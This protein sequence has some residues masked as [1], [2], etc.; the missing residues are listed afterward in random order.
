M[1][2]A[3]TLRALLTRWTRAILSVLT[4]AL[5]VAAVTAT[6][7]LI[8]TTHAAYTSLF[9]G[10]AAGAQIAVVPR[11]VSG[12]SVAL[13]TT[14]VQSSAPGSVPGLL[15]RR[16]AAQPGVSAAA[17]RV[18]EAATIIGRDGQP[19][20]G[21][22]LQTVAISALPA[23]FT[24]VTLLGGSAPTRPDQVA[25]DADT[26]TR[27]G[28]HVGSIIRVLTAQPARAFRVSAIAA[29][30]GGAGA[31]QRFVVFS[32]RTAQ[33]LYGIGDAYDEIEVAAA[34]GTDAGR[35]RGEVAALLPRGLEAV[36]TSTR[37]ASS[38]SRV[39]NSFRTLD[40]GLIAFAA[41]AVLI[42]S[43]IIFN[44][45]AA[46][47]TARRREYAV[48]RLL[49]AF[50]V[51]VLGSAL[52]EAGLIG[53]TGALL[54]V[55]L[56]LPL[57]LAIRAGVNAAG[58]DLPVSGL[59]IAPLALAVAFGVG[60]FVALAAALAP[61]LRVARASPA[62]ALRTGRGADRRSPVGRL[63][64]GAI[65]LA[66]ATG[67]GAGGVIVI[68][69]A[70]GDQS[71]RLV[72]CGIGVALVLLAAL[73]AAA[74]LVALTLLA[75][76]VVSGPRGRWRLWRRGRG[77]GEPRFGPVFELAREGALTSPGRR[78]RASPS[79]SPSCC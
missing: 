12:T 72:L 48:L 46:A 75:L 39:S 60:V 44:S 34:P 32:P 40:G 42:G 67:L 1:L 73:L 59:T 8:D 79:G 17:G 49:G 57:A 65:G 20:S 66:A 33:R 22:H 58:V 61:A 4:V 70:S 23:P 30:S 15:V 7:V 14:G 77:A 16:I 53:V 9:S 3:F 76:G 64:V 54:G 2:S 62:E 63:L 5:G 11:Q 78:P 51:Q 18:V 74:P 55:A 19:V 26:A 31:G 27:E 47:A 69:E 28:W 52:V 43:L 6:L 38:V 37:V 56:G 71:R 45:F 35:L 50:R 25:V 36:L 68:L 29:L 21:G 24:G 13:G 10:T 41:A